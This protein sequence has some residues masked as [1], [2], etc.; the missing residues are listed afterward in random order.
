M[1]FSHGNKSCDKKNVIIWKK[2]LIYIKMYGNIFNQRKLVV[3]GI[4][5]RGN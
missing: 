5:V 2:I 4:N 3:V 1:V